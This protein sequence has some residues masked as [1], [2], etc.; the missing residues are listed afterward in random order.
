[1]GRRLR[2]LLPALLVLLVVGWL[3]YAR[4]MTVQELFPGFSRDRVTQVQVAYNCFR[5]E[6]APNGKVDTI[7]TAGSGF[8]D[9]GEPQVAQLL[10]R[11]A[12]AEFS[13]SLLGTVQE[14]LSHSQ[15]GNEGYFLLLSLRQE[16]EE[17]LV[18]RV[19]DK[20]LTLSWGE[21]YYRCSWKNGPLMDD[22]FALAIRQFPG[23]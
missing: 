7:P 22:W 3:W 19:Y 1:M 11:T 23:P 13:R 21:T 12:Q 5:Q 2:Y 10:E 20:T 15:E 8:W 18:L 9:P 6:T 4:P 14:R 16:E 17:N